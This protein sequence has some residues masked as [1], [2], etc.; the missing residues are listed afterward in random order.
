MN[1]LPTHTLFI[2]FVADQQRSR[3]FY[4]RVLNSAPSLD[5]TGMTEF[6]LSETCKLGLMPDAGIA[7][8]ICPAMPDP[9]EAAGIPRCEIYLTVD[10]VDISFQH[11][12]AC[13]ARVIS[14][15]AVQNWGH[16]VGYLAD[17]DGHILAFAESIQQVS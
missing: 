13:G 2:L 11:A 5:V 4:S 9:S 1:H 6:T 12:V 17:P 14:S 3:N 16:R 7:R 10:N 8:I 15:P